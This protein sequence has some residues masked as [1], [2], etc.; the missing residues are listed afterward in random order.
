MPREARGQGDRGIEVAPRYVCCCIYEDGEGEAI[1][2][3]CHLI[4]GAASIDLENSQANELGQQSCPQLPTV[5]VN[6]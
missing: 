5:P 3:R 1:P 2:K 6:L 4:I